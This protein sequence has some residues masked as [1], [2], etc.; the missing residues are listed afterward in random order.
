GLAGGRDDGLGVPVAG[1]GRLATARA[2]ALAVTVAAA[3][4]AV[5]V[6]VALLAVAVALTRGLRRGR[7]QAALDVAADAEVVEQVVG[8]RVRLDRLVERQVERLVDELP[9]LQVRPVDERHGGAGRA[10]ARSEEHTSEFQS[11][12]NLVCRLPLEKKSL[13]SHIDAKAG[14]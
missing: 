9:A 7:L 6:A 8:G 3:A 2:C 14:R 13:L 1:L 5:A 11:R 10:R 12:E 4:L